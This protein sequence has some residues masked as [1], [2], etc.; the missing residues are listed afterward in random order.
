MALICSDRDRLVYRKKARSLTTEMCLCDI[1]SQIRQWYR[2]WLN[3][4]TG[5]KNVLR[6]VLFGPAARLIDARY[7]NEHRFKLKWQVSNA[8]ILFSFTC[9]SCSFSLAPFFSSRIEKFSGSKIAPKQVPPFHITWFLI[10]NYYFL[11]IN[12]N[13]RFSSKENIVWTK[14]LSRAITIVCKSLF[15]RLRTVDSRGL[16]SNY[17]VCILA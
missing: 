3:A 15:N 6:K 7:G 1:R 14:Q 9:I 16:A 11:N 8:N 2:T 17:R 10:C 12:V 5:I 13:R 4:S